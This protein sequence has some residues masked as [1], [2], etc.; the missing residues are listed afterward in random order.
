MTARF[1]WRARHSFASAPELSAGEPLRELLA[2]IEEK[3]RLVALLTGCNRNA[4][5]RAHPGGRKEINAAGEHLSLITAPYSVGDQGQ[6]SLGVL[7]PM[8]MHYE[9]AITAVVYVARA[10]S[11]MRGG[12]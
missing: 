11:E 3:S 4:R 12:S 5:G 7:A 2:A 6:G 8:R 10:F 1:T 9:R